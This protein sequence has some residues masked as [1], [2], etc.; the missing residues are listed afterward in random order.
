[1]VELRGQIDTQLLLLSGL[2]RTQ[3][4]TASHRANEVM[5]ATSSWGAILVVATLITGVYDM[6]FRTMPELRW[7]SSRAPPRS[8]AR[9]RPAA[10]CDTAGAHVPG[11]D[12]GPPG[13]GT[14]D[15]AHRPADAAGL[16]PAWE[17]DAVTSTHERTRT[18]VD[19]AGRASA[20]GRGQ[21]P[22][23]RVAVSLSLAVGA[24]A[25]VTALA[26]LLSTGGE[27]GTVV[28]TVSNERIVLHGHGLYR[29][30]TVFVAGSNIGSDITTLLFGL[31]L[32]ATAVA[33]TRRGSLRGRLLL[34]GVLGYLLYYGA[35]YAL[36]AVAYNELFL[37]YVALF[38]AALSAFVAAFVAADPATLVD[39]PRRPRR[40]IG[41][42]MV[43]SGVATL[44]I[45]LADPLGALLTGTPP[46]SL[47]THTT[48]FT[49]ALDMAVIVPSAVTAGVLILRSRPPGAVVAASLLVLEAL[50][51]PLIVVTTIVQMRMGVSFTPAEV[52]G[53]IVG[54]SVFGVLAAMTLT[55]LLRHVGDVVVHDDGP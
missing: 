17:V 31:P 42:F 46:A 6:N 2:S 49:H 30:D 18:V 45:W 34:V 35:G 50:L 47:G 28:T 55:I 11:P 51:L 48:L 53:P 3:V 8:T 27:G 32:L 9:S 24:L 21:W 44:G 14:L 19:A 4:V 52:I 20:P 36:G 23:A 38:S 1:M 37:V 41:G 12:G 10:G 40:W 15:P 5:Q 25:L 26:G 29:H 7:E 43:A 22:A 13:A 54:F 39:L 33:A 16:A